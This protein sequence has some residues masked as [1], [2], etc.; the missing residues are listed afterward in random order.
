MNTRKARRMVTA[1]IMAAALALASLGSVGVSANEEQRD[2]SGS[3]NAPQQAVVSP[4]TSAYTV[5]AV[6]FVTPGYTVNNVPF[7][8]VS[9]G[10]VDNSL[11]RG[12]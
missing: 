6:P 8:T 7:V 3:F 2:A 9:A 11:D 5:N 4:F 10:Q 12:N 1:G